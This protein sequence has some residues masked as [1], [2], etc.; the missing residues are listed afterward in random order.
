MEEEEQ[1]EEEEEEEEVIEH[2]SVAGL[3]ALE[4]MAARAAAET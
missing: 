4:Q 3:A 1:Q 2:V